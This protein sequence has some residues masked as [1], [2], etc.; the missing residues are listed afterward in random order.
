M[1]S[2]VKVW[3]A[4]LVT[5]AA[6]A[7]PVGEAAADAPVSVTDF[8]GRTLT[9]PRPV[10]RIVCLIESALSGLYMLGAGERVVGIPA[11]VYQEPVF[12]YYARLDARIAARTLPAPGSWDFFSTERV[13]ALKPEVVIVWAHQTEAIA[14]LESR[15][16]PVFGVFLATVG[17]VAREIRE[18]G[19]LTGTE[20]RAEELLS[21][22]REELARVSRRLEGL[23]AAARPRVYFMWAQSPLET[24]GGTSTV[25][26]LIE[27]AGGRNVLA[28]LPQEHLRVKQEQLLVAN[29]EVIVMWHNP[30]LDP[31]DL[32]ALPAWQGLAAVKAGRVYEL[33]PV[34]VCDLWTLKYVHAV[35]L[36]A[37]WLHPARFADLNLAAEENRMLRALYQGRLGEP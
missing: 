29:P 2:L 10:S 35:K 16:I 22:T 1:L 6:L 15:G 30:R 31:A 11:S 9:F 14:A 28:H 36:L 32:L 17:D 21:W 23:P 3:L 27:L 34:F 12:H 18:L 19:R 26:D 37:A 8:R 4:A 24:S 33:P 25:H 20:A 13:L 5:L 7:A